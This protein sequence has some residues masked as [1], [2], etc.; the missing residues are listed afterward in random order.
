[1]PKRLPPVDL[2]NYA[3]SVANKLVANIGLSNA[4]KVSIR[5]RRLLAA[6]KNRRKILKIPAGTYIGRYK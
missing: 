5:V 2:D 6:E 4:C 1:M 3:T